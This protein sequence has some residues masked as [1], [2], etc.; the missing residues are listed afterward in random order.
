MRTL[1]NDIIA[2]LK[3][4]LIGLGLAGSAF[5]AHYYD[6]DHPGHGVSMTQDNGQ[7]SAF[8]WYTYNRDG[9]NRWLI[10]TDNCYTFPCVIPLAEAQGVWMGGDVEL[11][12]VGVA[13]IIF[14]DG[15]MTWDYDLRDWPEAGECG[16]LIQNIMNKCVGT[17]YMER[18]D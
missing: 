14:N 17:F 18:V 13:T 4:G 5:G 10:S 11:E 3:L 7:G 9:D 12:E 15:V 8:V 2:R 16:R 6:P 1:I